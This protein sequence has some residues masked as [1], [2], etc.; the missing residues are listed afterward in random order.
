MRGGGERRQD[1][2]ADSRCHPIAKARTGAAD[3]FDS[4]AEVAELA[5]QGDDLHIHGAV[6]DG[7]VAAVDRL[8]DLRPRED[9]ARPTRQQAQQL[10][11]GGGQVHGLIAHAHL[12]PCRID[13]QVVHTNDRGRRLDHAVTGSL[14][15]L[16]HVSN[17]RQQDAGAERLGDIVGGAQFQTGDDIRLFTLGR[18]HDDGDFRVLTVGGER[19][20]N[21]QAVNPRQHQVQQ[22]QVRLRGL[23]KLERLGAVFRDGHAK[24]IA[25]EVVTQ[26][27]AQ[28]LLILH[29]EQVGSEDRLVVTRSLASRFHGNGSHCRHLAPFHLLI[30]RGPQGFIRE[31]HRTQPLL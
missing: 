10:E 20:T 2:G 23:D 19:A 22:N 9:A 24:A 16:E 6:G 7:D 15:A 5:A 1:E 14:T 13:G 29:H 26:Q 31:A 12:V 27:L 30:S 18:E 8:D 17:P 4:L 11:L 21:F 25:F 3:S 28:V